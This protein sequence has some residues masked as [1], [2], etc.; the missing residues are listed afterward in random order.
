M[1]TKRVY[2]TGQSMGCMMTM[3]LAAQ[4][5]GLYTAVMLVSGQWETSALSGLSKTPFFYIA[6][7]GDSKS[8]GGQKDVKAMFDS[9]GVSY[10]SATW[11]ATWSAA[12]L[13]AAAKTLFAK[14][15]T[16]S[17]ASFATGTVLKANPGAGGMEHMASFEPAY[18]ITAARDWLFA[19]TAS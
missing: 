6:A 10:A 8:S 11:D 4:N 2:G 16:H 5:P 1:D 7:G 15:D 13:N 9:Q 3:Y 12:R 14:N 18:K 19:Q 17:F